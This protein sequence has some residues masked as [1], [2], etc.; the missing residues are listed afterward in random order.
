MKVLGTSVP[1]FTSD[2][3]AAI[4]R[5][6]T[7]TGEVVRQRFELPEGGLRIALLGSVTIIAGSEQAGGALKD[8]RAT[9]IVDSLADYE[10]HLRSTGATVLQGRSRTPAG[11]QLII[12]DVEGLVFEFVEPHLKE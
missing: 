1:I 5:Y 11:T 12:R 9:F 4:E 10:A 8:V 7:L 6:G 2:F 3:E